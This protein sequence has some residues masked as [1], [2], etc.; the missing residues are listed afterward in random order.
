MPSY[1]R[2]VIV[3]PT[4]SVS[5]QVRS[6][7]NLL[8]RIATLIE[9]QSGAD[10]L[11]ELQYGKCTAVIA[12]WRLEDMQGWELSAR[13]QQKFPNMPTLVVADYDDTEI[14]VDMLND[15]PFAYLKRPYDSSQFLRVIE[16]AL[17]NKS[18][19]EA[20]LMPVAEK[21]QTQDLEFGGVPNIDADAAKNIVYQLRSDLNAISTYLI[22]RDGKVLVDIGATGAINRDEL[23]NALMPAYK[24]FLQMRPHIG[25]TTPTLF[26]FFD[27]E[28]YDIYVL[29]A[30]FHHMLVVVFDGQK[31]NREL[32]AVRN[33]GKR[34]VDGLTA[35]LG[36]TAWMTNAPVM[37]VTSVE[38]QVEVRHRPRQRITS[39]LEQEPVLAL[40]EMV[41]EEKPAKKDSTQE[42]PA[43]QLDV[44]QGDIDM[45]LLFAGNGNEMPDLFSLDNIEMELT[46]LDDKSTGGKLDWD[47]AK[48]LGL[49]G[50]E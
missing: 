29:G 7:L 11:E 42:T 40:A 43:L 19:K 50:G 12:A 3:D 27:G 35:L 41:V 23:G 21:K 4:E 6:A 36:M 30:G 39:T 15:S 14:D 25:G 16:A 48:E 18:L 17:N 49:L 38:E 45:D 9:V 37:V 20:L 1:A 44:I 33:F 5:T 10:A 2:L 8:D 26:Q 47:K 28:G 24:S 46:K 34:A 31:G 22:A 32:G 13:I